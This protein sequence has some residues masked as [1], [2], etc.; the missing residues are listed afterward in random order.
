M[1]KLCD[2]I[3]NKWLDIRYGRFFDLFEKVI[4]PIVN[5]IVVVLLIPFL[6]YCL[7]DMYSEELV[8]CYA[9]LL[10]LAIF[11]GIELCGYLL[12]GFNLL[13]A[14]HYFIVFFIVGGAMIGGVIIV[15]MAISGE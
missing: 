7:I 11:A 8:I 2:C 14:I 6:L 12:L 15:G 4:F 3:E 9:F 13:V 10:V 5:L 1:N